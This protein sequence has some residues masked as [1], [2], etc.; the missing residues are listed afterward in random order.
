MSAIFFISSSLNF[1]IKILTFSLISL[2]FGSQLKQVNFFNLNFRCIKK[3]EFKKLESNNPR[4]Q[5]EK[6][7]GFIM[8]I[9]HKNL[10]HQIKLVYK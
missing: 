4:N 5:D 2:I 1:L 10:E 6:T 7:V 8:N 3:K 9:C